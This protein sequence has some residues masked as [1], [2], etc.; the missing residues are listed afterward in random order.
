MSNND[1]KD[2]ELLLRSHVPLLAVETDEE[3]RVREL[4]CRLIPKL[5]RPLFTW[6]ITD[7]L[8]R[9]DLEAPPMQGTADPGD[10]LRH[11]RSSK[12]SAV[13]LVPDLHP[14]VSD[15]INVRL[16]KEI[17]QTYNQTPR[18][19]ALISHRFEHPPELRKFIARFEPSLPD[20][21]ALLRI[22][23]EEATAW[24]QQNG[25][26][27][28]RTDR[29]TLEKLVQN[30]AGLTAWDARRL[31]RSAIQ[32]DGA[33]TESDLPGVMEAKY[34]LLDRG[35]ALSFTYDTARFSEVGGLQGLKRWLE[36]RR[37]A[38]LDPEAGLDPP[39]GILLV[40]VQG[41]GK[42]LAAKAVAGLWGLPLLGLDMGTL[43]NKYYGES[44]RNLR[45]ALRSAEVMAPCVLWVDEIEK[46]LS[47][48]ASDGGVSQRMLGSLL[49]WMAENRNH[50][51]LVATANAIDKL[52]PELIRKGRMDEIFFVD[53]PTAEV[54]AEIFRIHMEKRSLDPEAFDLERLA[55]ASDG[56]SGAEIEQA[57]V[58]GLYLA[59]EQEAALTT[60]HLLTEIRETRPLSVVMKENL[61]RLRAWAKDRTVPAG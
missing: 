47:Q 41:G 33:I 55:S 8:R 54:R 30:L 10:F 29:S 12:Q 44:E 3:Q 27:R 38:F 43:Y 42:S 21:D 20:R 28:V 60:T 18:T 14:Y 35:G 61:D 56:F 7:G 16:L 13:Y 4:F 22:V 26:Q 45:E 48:S 11:V 34:Q 59:R 57:V 40:G 25:G 50:V 23:N 39:R 15:P 6:S 52:P 58:A 53:L 49:T 46:A 17:A 5:G 1:I 24:A 36:R 9:L 32:N 2:L 31:A 37:H 19:M 51:F